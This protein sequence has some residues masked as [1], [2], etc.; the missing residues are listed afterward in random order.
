MQVVKKKWACG[1]V[2]ALSSIGIVRAD[3]NNVRQ[4]VPAGGLGGLQSVFDDLYVSGPGIDAEGDQ[5]SSAL[6]TSTA[7]GGS[8]ATFVIELASFAPTTRFGIYSASDPTNKAEVFDGIDG[9]GDQAIISFFANG[10]IKVNFATVATDF[11]QNWGF[12]I[13]VYGAGGAQ[14]GDDDGSTFDY[15][16]YSE[17]S[18]N[19]G[20]AAQALIYQGD[21][22]TELQ[23]ADFLPGEFSDNEVIVAF[24]DTLISQG[25]SDENYT[26]LVVLVE[27]VKPI[28]A[29]GAALLAALGLGTIGWF[30]RRRA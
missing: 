26:D 27:S 20:D 30:R 9:A 13:D 29:P 28:P 22:A 11:N 8:V 4:H 15:T 1:L 14:G 23:I 25:F 10:T 17:D 21:D 7:S 3:P 12:Y 24:E 18:L 2:V 5:I 19:P 6:F 16:L